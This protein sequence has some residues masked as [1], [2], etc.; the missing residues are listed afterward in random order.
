[1]SAGFDG[2]AGCGR[3]TAVAG[4]HPGIS[5]GPG[6]AQQSM[7]ALAR[8]GLPTHVYV[9]PGTYTVTMTAVDLMNTSTTSAFTGQMMVRNGRLSAQ[10][11]KQVVIAP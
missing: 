11:T 1:M 6:A 9:K 10:T 2:V 4:D 3:A 7:G 8:G 5:R